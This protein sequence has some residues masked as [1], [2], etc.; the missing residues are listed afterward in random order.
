[1][2]VLGWEGS[3]WEIDNWHSVD[4]WGLGASA[5]CWGLVG[6]RDVP[7][8]SV[9]A[10]DVRLDY[11]QALLDGGKLILRKGT[12]NVF[13]QVLKSYFFLNYSNLCAKAKFN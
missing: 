2:V 3:W 4:C 7:P 5:D 10:K 13:F 6:R 8:S 1:M 11:G 12:Q 9:D